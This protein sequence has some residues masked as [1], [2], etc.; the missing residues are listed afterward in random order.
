MT[1]LSAWWA[2]AGLLAV[3]II[4]LY[5]LKM[6]RRPT[7]VSSTLLWEQVLS[8]LRANTPFQ[9]LRRNLL[10]ILQLITLAI[11]VFALCQP[12]LRAAGIGGTESVVI[13]DA[14]ASMEAH[15]MPDG[16][17]RFEHAVAQAGT[18]IDNL[19]GGDSIML[20]VAGPPG[21]G[22]R[23]AF[24]SSKAELRAALSS[25]VCYDAPAA[26]ADALRLGVSSLAAKD[27]QSL[28]GKVY[29]LSD[30]AGVD[31]PDVN[32]LEQAL[33]YVRIGQTDSNV[34]ITALSTQVGQGGSQQVVVGVGNFGSAAQN[35]MVDLYFG[36]PTNWVDSRELVVPA[37]A[38]RTAALTTHLPPGRLWVRLKAAQ[39]ALELDNMGYVLLPEPRK[40]MVRLV[41]AGNPVLSRYLDTAQKAGLLD[42]AVTPPASY[43]GDEPANVTILDGTAPAKL[44]VGDVVLIN[45]PGQAAGFTRTGEMDAP[46]V[47]NA[48]TEADVLRFVNT[49]DLG[50]AKA[51]VYTHDGSATELIGGSQ[52]PLV[53]YTANGPDRRYL[54][55]FDLV[56]STWSTEPGIL[57]LLSNIL[58]RTAPRSSSGRPRWCPPAPPPRCRAATSRPS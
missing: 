45:P 1:I 3:P 25:A 51:G 14:S 12:V 42:Q 31:L 15:D 2:L 27:G 33:E 5:L 34:G 17:S 9:K 56:D 24:T 32:L 39:D 58:D 18:L 46:E 30:G 37:G 19:R 44:P 21:Q 41:S 53:A 43:T 13:I 20:I 47:I 52:G 4:I 35:V 49:A 22:A 16:K 54:I 8:D 26:V 57:I 11:L 55:A 36:S 10:M 28:R 38:Q 48:A 29:L 7:Q 23:T 40:L 6:R 50:V